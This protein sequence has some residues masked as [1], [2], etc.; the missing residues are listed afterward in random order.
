MARKRDRIFAGTI[1][2]LFIFTS[3][4]V[5]IAVI[6]QTIQQ[7]KK[8]DLGKAATNTSQ[9]TEAQKQQIQQQANSK[10]SNVAKLQGTQ[11]TGFTPVS[12]ITSLQKI[13]STPGTGAT[14]KAG[15]TVTVD[16]TGAVASTGVIFQSSKDSGQ[17]VPL[18]LSQ[19]I[20]GWSQGI[21][22]M[23]VGGTRRLLIPASLAYGSNPPS[24]SGIPS[25]AD[26]VFDVTVVKIGK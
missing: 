25:N 9:L 13:D 17:P 1:A 20:A 18:S 11:L 12:N 3:S 7:N 16:Y 26:L 19:V 15:D 2:G 14:V 22:G 5:T 24:G 8:P 21:P 6:Y 23:Q 10:D 4:A